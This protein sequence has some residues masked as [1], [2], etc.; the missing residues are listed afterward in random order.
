M[1]NIAYD[2]IANFIASFSLNCKD[3]HYGSL[4]EPHFNHK[5]FPITAEKEK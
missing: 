3:E 4:T 2:L 5:S 1:K